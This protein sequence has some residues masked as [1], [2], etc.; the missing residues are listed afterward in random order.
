[1]TTSI[2]VRLVA[3]I[4]WIGFVCAI[5]FMEAWIKF[6]AP[7]VTIAAG[8]AIGQR[9]FW[10]LNKVEITFAIVI[11]AALYSSF[12]AKRGETL[13]LFIA[14]SVLVVQTIYFLPALSSRIDQYL[15]GATPGHSSLHTWYIAGEVTK[16]IKLAV[17]GIRHL[18]L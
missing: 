9:V 4:L 7:G 15:A 6:T 11:L 16:V 1:M 17:A 14:I 5:S 18:F 2:K 12:H 10:A 8:L 13:L 3:I